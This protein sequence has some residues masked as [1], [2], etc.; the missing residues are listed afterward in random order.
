MCAK[1]FRMPTARGRWPALVSRWACLLTLLAAASARAARGDESAPAPVAPAPA[2]LSG[3][4]AS[5]STVQRVEIAAT[6]DDRRDASASKLVVSA[7]ELRRHG[8]A[9]LSAAL[10]RV[11]GLTV[12]PGKGQTGSDIRVRGLGNGYTQLLVNG[13]PVPAGFSVDSLSPDLIDRVE[14]LRS[15][16]ADTSAQ[17]IAGSVNIVLRQPRAGSS[18]DM[19]LGTGGYADRLSGSSTLQYGGAQGPLR[20]ALGAGLTHDRNQWPSTVD[21][22]A[23][24]AGAPLRGGVAWQGLG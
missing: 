3:A 5:D 24:Q 23:T 16:A 20:Y 21:Q 11:P 6:A 4:P 15:G 1:F 10:Q 18:T 2:P 9:S 13:E 12:T 19:K 17:A 8:D 7:T 14:V 22:R